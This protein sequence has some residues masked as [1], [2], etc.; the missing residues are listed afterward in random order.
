MLKK[1]K[2]IVTAFSFLIISVFIYFS[3]K[4]GS[5]QEYSSFSLSISLIFWYLIAIGGGS[6]A[7]A[8]TPHKKS[9]KSTVLY[10]FIGTLN[11]LIAIAWLL[12]FYLEG[13]KHLNI[14]LIYFII[15]FLLGL[16]I[17][18]NIYFKEV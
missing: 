9:N 14:N 12:F 10:I 5:N 1:N 11:V 18:R 17:F 13:G 6:V 4:A 2:Y 3:Y 16:I 15:P 7:I 8:I